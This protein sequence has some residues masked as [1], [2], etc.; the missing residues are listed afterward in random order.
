MPTAI[1]QHLS[2]AVV[3]LSI[4][5]LLD[6]EL[7]KSFNESE[8]RYFDM[9][10]KKTASLIESSAYCA[11][12][13]AQKDCEAY[14]MYGK[15]LGLS[16]QIIDD[17]LDITQD[18]KTLGKPALNDFK[19][20]KTTLPYIYL[21]QDLPKDDKITLLQFFQKELDASQ[22][23][24]IKQKMSEYKSI[25]KSIQKARSLGNE[26]LAKIDKNDKG[27]IEVMKQMIDREF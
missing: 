24:W 22:V 12:Y 26:A 23:S 19:E 3:Q 25:E 10:Y 13:L 2:N 7:A 6:V 20:G 27:L 21:Y 5:E 11:A 18:A 1:A 15:H 17:I 4:G 8:D 16:F 9:I 14:A